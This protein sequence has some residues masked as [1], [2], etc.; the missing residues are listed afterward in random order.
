MSMPFQYILANLIAK[1]EHAVGSLFLDPTGETIDLA[2]S[3]LSPFQMKVLGAYLGI[4]LRQ[5]ERV[6]D[7]EGLGAPRCLTL[8]HQRL[9]L[10]VVPLADG[11]ALA[12]VQRPPAN[13][14]R[15]Q[16]LLENAADVMERE[17]LPRRAL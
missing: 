10:H 8:H 9:I 7:A 3:E 5:M 2:C 15:A 4:H 16:R 13:L 11:Y 12:L 1:A 14:G 17:V 6:L